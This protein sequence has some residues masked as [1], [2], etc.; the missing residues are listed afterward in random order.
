LAEAS[1]RVSGAIT[2]IVKPLT[3]STEISDERRVLAEQIGEAATDCWASPVASNAT[4][5]TRMLA[6][7]VDAQM[8]AMGRF[9]PLLR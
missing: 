4:N 1:F 6:N 9:L 3:S 2:E 7:L 5:A 8:S